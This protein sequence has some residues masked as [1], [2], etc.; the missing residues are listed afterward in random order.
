MR[1]LL[2]VLCLGALGL[3]ATYADAGQQRTPGSGRRLAGIELGS[4]ERVER[5][6][7][8][9]KA[10]ARHTPGE[11]DDELEEVATWSQAD[12]KALYVDA[13]VLVVLGRRG[14]AGDYR[15][16]NVRYSKEQAHRMSVL[17]CA[18]DGAVFESNCMAIKAGEELD[19]DLR[20][21][22]VL[23]RASNLRGDRNY[24]ERRG[25]LF[26]SD[27][28]M[29]APDTMAAPFDLKPSSLGPQRFRMEISDGREV[30]LRQSAVHWELARML[31]D[32]VAPKGSDHAAPGRDEMVRQWYRATAAWMQLREDHDELHINHARELFPDDPDIL[33]LSA[34]QRETYAGP[35]IQTA[36]RSAVLPTGVTMGVGSEQMELKQAEQ[37]FRRTL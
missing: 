12:L 37:L 22:A 23:S 7:R 11:I 33:F 15:F 16:T 8:W 3:A 35:P 6:E 36:V 18:A 24:V 2:V 13:N 26:H 28:A 34:C 17:A 32:L 4:P 29:L 1:G 14:H 5:L 9:L 30:D 31:L 21:L 25:A 27:V 20:Q 19:A 10:V